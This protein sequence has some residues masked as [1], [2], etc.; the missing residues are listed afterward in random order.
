MECKKNFMLMILSES[1]KESMNVRVEKKKMT[2]ITGKKKRDASDGSSEEYWAMNESLTQL[3]KEI[4]FE[5]N[6]KMSEK[7]FYV[8]AKACASSRGN[9]GGAA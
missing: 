9:T 7:L 6:Y 5:V 4:K 3:T 8:L 2:T 1:H